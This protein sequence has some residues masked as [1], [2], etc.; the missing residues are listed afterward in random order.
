MN[1]P[2][3]TNKKGKILGISNGISQ[4][5]RAFI[6]FSVCIVSLNHYFFV[7]AMQCALYNVF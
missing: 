1:L 4:L 2:N 5:S 6:L 3:P 7:T